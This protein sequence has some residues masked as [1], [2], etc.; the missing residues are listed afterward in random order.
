[1]I[2]L[3]DHYFYLVITREEPLSNIPSRCAGKLKRLNESYVIILSTL[4]GVLLL[5]ILLQALILR[6]RR[7]IASRFYPRRERK[8]IAYLY[9]KLL[10]ERKMFYK[11][12]IEKM[13]NFSEKN[14]TL[15]RLDAVLVLCNNFS[16]IKTLFEFVGV[17]IQRCSVCGT[18]LNRKYLHCDTEDCGVYYC[19]TCFWDLENKC[20]GCMSNSKMTSRSSSMSGQSQRRKNDYVKPVWRYFFSIA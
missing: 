20:L 12:V 1:M 3:L 17:S 15:N 13:N 14:E 8:R 4:L 11:S 7:L 16:W 2:I 5:I 18:G 6:L 10:E 19:R 9:Y